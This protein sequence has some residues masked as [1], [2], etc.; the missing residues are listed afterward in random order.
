M[1][2][3]SLMARGPGSANHQIAS[4]SSAGS[5]LKD[6][7]DVPILEG[8]EAS[9]MVEVQSV[10]VVSLGVE[11]VIAVLELE[12]LKSVMHNEAP[13][14]KGKSTKAE[15]IVLM[16]HFQYKSRDHATSR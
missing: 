5:F 9:F 16:L 12:L 2:A 7:K 15:A 8:L 14:L 10:A 4:R 11:A 3:K 13:E 6:L 1:S